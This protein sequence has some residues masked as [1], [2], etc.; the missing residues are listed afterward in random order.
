[1]KY[2]RMALNMDD[3]LMGE[4]AQCYISDDEESYKPEPV[5]EQPRDQS[6]PPPGSAPTR[7]QTG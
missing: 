1:M 5:L 3:R 2:F 4:T 7:P 6:R